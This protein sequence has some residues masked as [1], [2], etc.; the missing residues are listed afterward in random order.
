MAHVSVLRTDERHDEQ[1][2]ELRWTWRVDELGESGGTRE[3]FMASFARW[4]DAHRTS[5]HGYLALENG[6][7]V[8]VAWLAISDRVPSPARPERSSGHVQ[9][10]FVR[11]THRNRGVGSLMVKELIADA[12][13]LGLDY[14]ILHPTLRSVPMYRRLGFAESDGLLELRFDR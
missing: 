13:A 2:G 11:A 7:P 3:Q 8:G 9:S 10:V 5:H 14:L 4:L 6:K 1:L 12:N